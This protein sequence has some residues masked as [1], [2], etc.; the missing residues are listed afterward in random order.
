M[1]NEERLVDLK[2]KLKAR[3]N[4]NEYR[5]NVVKLRAEIAR[6]EQELRHE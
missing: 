5:E 4:K 6:I 3:Q 2:A 1:T